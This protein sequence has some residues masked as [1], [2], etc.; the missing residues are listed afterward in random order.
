MKK[1]ELRLKRAMM[2]MRVR[3]IDSCGALHLPVSDFDFELC[4]AFFFVQFCVPLPAWQR[5]LLLS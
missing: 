2:V 1:W 3:S 4:A 5:F